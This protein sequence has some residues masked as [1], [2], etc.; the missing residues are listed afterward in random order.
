MGPGRGSAARRGARPWSALDDDRSGFE[1]G[2][3]TRS[4]PSSTATTAASGSA[5]P[6]RSSR[7]WSRRSSSRRSPAPRPGA[8]CAGSSAAGASRRPGPF[9]PAAAARAGGPRRDRRTTRSTRSASSAAGR[10]SSGGS[11]DRA[12]RFEEIRRPG[13]ATTAYARLTAL[14]GIGP[15]TAAEVA[16]PRARRPRRGERR[17]LP[18]A[19]RR[20]LRPGRRD[21]RDRRRMLELLEPW[22][23][24]AGPGDPAAR[25][26]RPPAAGFGPRLRSALDR[27]DLS[28]RPVARG[29][30]A[31]PAL[32]EDRAPVPAG[33][34]AT[35]GRDPAPTGRRSARTRTTGA[36]RAAG[37]AR[38][39]SGPRPRAGQRRSR[40]RRSGS[41]SRRRSPRRD[42]PNRARADLERHVL[43]VDAGPDDHEGDRS[44]GLPLERL[45]DA[46]DRRAETADLDGHGAVGVEPVAE[47]VPVDPH[48]APG[49]PADAAELRG[50]GSIPKAVRSIG[51][52]SSVCGRRDVAGWSSRW[53]HHRE[54]A[55]GGLSLA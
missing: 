9:G 29:G 3:S 35:G 6:A 26:Q 39:A 27:R 19:E 51:R 31:L 23:G 21:P 32:G 43:A 53:M 54:D 4:S 49:Q 16:A 33:G 47:R 45:G 38:T 11:R 37:A 28:R 46:G 8:G 18:P 36:P 13:R 34:R 12:A 41:P 40:R 14:P 5:R 52:S 22:R 10:T 25:A 48:P 24:P 17:R 55:S 2:P 44:I 7:R 30:R 50:G 15:W 1:A 20:R 42:G